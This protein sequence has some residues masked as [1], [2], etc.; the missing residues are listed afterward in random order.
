MKGR[1]FLGTKLTK[2]DIVRMK[3]PGG[4]VMTYLLLEAVGS[5]PVGSLTR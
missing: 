4:F 3:S 5:V 2:S 1:G